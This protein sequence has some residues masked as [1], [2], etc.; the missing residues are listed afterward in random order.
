[1][2]YRDDAKQDTSMQGTSQIRVQNMPTSADLVDE[3]KGMYRVLELI[4]ESGTNG[5]G[6]ERPSGSWRIPP[7][8]L[9]WYPS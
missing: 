2:P 1:M 7:H 3:V 8:W 9:I 5:Y 6:K 4:S